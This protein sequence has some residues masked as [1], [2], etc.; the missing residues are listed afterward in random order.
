MSQLDNEIKVVLI[1]FR[2]LGVKGKFKDFP[3]LQLEKLQQIKSF[4]T[5]K[6][7]KNL[8]QKK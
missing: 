6:G 5:E 8:E 7:L 1:P 2:N 4:L 3:S